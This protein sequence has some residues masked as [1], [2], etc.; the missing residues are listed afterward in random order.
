MNPELTQYI[1]ETGNEFYDSLP[2]AATS[3]PDT[4]AR[5]WIDGFLA[6]ELRFI[7]STLRRHLND[8]ATDWN[9]QAGTEVER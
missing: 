9:A 6:N 5:D 7:E 1:I 3:D 2:N 8:V 4:N